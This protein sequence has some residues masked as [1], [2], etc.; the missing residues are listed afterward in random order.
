MNLG[1]LISDLVL[2]LQRRD[3]FSDLENLNSD[4]DGLNSDLVRLFI[5][6]LRDFFS[7]LDNLSSDSDD[8]FLPGP[9]PFPTTTGSFF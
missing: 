7:D 4:L 6:L 5:P 1:H 2:P 3:F 9:T 8:L